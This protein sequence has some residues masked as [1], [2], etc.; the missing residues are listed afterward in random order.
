MPVL[1][2]RQ[3]AAA[4]ELAEWWED[5]WQRGIGPQVALLQVPSGWGRSTVLDQANMVVSAADSPVTLVVRINGRELPDGLGLQAAV[6]SGVLAD[7]GARHRV[8][9]LLGLDRLAGGVQ[10]GLGVG[11][12]FVSGFAAALGF[13]LG[14][15]A[16]GA[17][18][19]IW[20]D[21]PA[22]RAALSP[23]RPA[24]WPKRR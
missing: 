1:G 20:D 14:G 21:S 8:V 9:E 5:L 19:K 10:L 7:A 16:V 15:L 23:G 22:G 17:A 2:P 6:L 13:L 24:R 4:G 12:L 18:G 3:E 11:G